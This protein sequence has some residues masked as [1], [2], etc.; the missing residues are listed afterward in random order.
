MFSHITIGTNDLA[1]AEAFYSHVLSPLGAVLVHRDERY[2]GYCTGG[3]TPDGRP[4]RPMFWVCLPYDGRAATVGNGTH[5]AF[6]TEARALVDAVYSIALE[7][8]ARDE[9]RPG[10]RPQYHEHYY[11]AYFRDMDGN[12]IQIC[13]HA[14]DAPRRTSPGERTR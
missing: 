5:V 11:G 13:C 7:S 6:L 8:G 2:V 9:G 10:L 14:E 3:L 1:R 4:R 12:K